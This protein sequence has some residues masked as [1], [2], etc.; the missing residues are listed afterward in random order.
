MHRLRRQPLLALAVLLPV[1]VV[2]M[3]ALQS[4]APIALRPDQVS[5]LRAGQPAQVQR[6]LQSL[7]D[8]RADLGLDGNGGFQGNF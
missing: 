6:V 1:A 4:R 3:G 5:A 8:R 2:G 7:N